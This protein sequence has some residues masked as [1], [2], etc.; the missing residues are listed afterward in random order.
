MM[1]QNKDNPAFD[2]TKDLRHIDPMLFLGSHPSQGTPESEMQN[3]SQGT[4]TFT[5]LFGKDLPAK[6][7]PPPLY[8]FGVLLR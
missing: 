6:L 3:D 7:N 1:K 5:L 8:M 2:S 4:K